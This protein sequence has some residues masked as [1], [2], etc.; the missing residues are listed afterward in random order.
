M[1]LCILEEVEWRVMPRCGTTAGI[2]FAT[3]LLNGLPHQCIRTLYVCILKSYDNVRIFP[4]VDERSDKE[5][6]LERD[7]FIVMFQVCA[8]VA[9]NLCACLYN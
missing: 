5:G 7:S 4:P 3:G 6:I 2:L 9:L 1:E 8:S